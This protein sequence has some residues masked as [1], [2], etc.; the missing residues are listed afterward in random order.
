VALTSLVD[1]LHQSRE[2]QDIL[3]R[4]NWTDMYLSGPAFDAFLKEEDA[5]ARTVL[6][7]IG[8]VK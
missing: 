4:N 2:W 5:R 1:R 6:R 7:S 3:T 8:L